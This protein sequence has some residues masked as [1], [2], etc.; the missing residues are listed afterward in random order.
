VFT[1]TDDAGRT[2][3]LSR[4]VTRVVSLAPSFTE[5]IYAI[6]GEG[7][8]VAVTTYCDYPEEATLKPKI[9]DFLNPSIEK[10][11]ALKPDCVLATDP[12]QA[13][14]SETLRK[15]GIKVV[16]LNPES[17]AGVLKCILEIGE[18]LDRKAAADSLVSE[19]DSGAERLRKSAPYI[20][21]KKVFLEI[22]TNPLVSAGRASFVG[23]LLALAGGENI[24][25][26]D[27]KYPV[28]NAEL[29]IQKDPDVIVLANP[30]ITV[31]EVESRI[32]W[33]QVSAVRTG[34]VV[35]IDPSVISRP[36]P[37]AIKGALELR[38]LIYPEAND[39]KRGD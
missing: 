22:D 34:M 16:Q 32:G 9:G 6:G 8:L 7:R 13:R 25:G 27:S 28:I 10:I 23:E 2:V 4:P 3:S 38:R 36:G 18:I 15:L 26:S 30:A 21:K 31:K 1:L 39:K 20:N 14:A 35:S 24:I 19:L 29:V 17:I 12:T 11:I 33:G 5:I 37:R